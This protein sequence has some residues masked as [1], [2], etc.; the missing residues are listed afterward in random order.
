MLVHYRWLWAILASAIT[1]SC[2]APVPPVPTVSEWT[3]SVR[4]TAFLDTLER[5]TFDFFWERTNPQNG[6]TPD[7]WPTRS[8]SSIAA[9]GF[10]LTSYPIGVERGY[11]TRP[12]AR[13]RVLTTLKFFWQAPQ[14]EAVTG[15]TGNRG[16]FYHFLDLKTGQRFERVELSTIDTTLLLGGI[17]FCQVYF[18]GQDPG[19]LAIRAYADSIY[20]RVDWRW[21]QQRRPLVSMGWD[22]TEGW[23]PYDWR[24]YNEAMLLYILALGSP[25]FPLDPAAWTAYTSSFRWGRFYGQEH[26]GFAPLFGH[27]YSHSFI[28]FRG[29]QDS[30]MRRRGIDYFENSRRATYGQRVYAVVNPG[31]WAGYGAQEWGLT[32]SDGPADTTLE[33]GGR[34]RKFMEY[35]ARGASFIE[36]RDDG[37]VAPT[38]A[39]G[40]LAFAPEIAL[41]A[42][43]SMREKHGDDVFGQY[44]FLDAFNETFP[45]NRAPGMGR[46]IPGRGW[47]DTDYLG[48]DQGPILIMAENYRT[49]LVW[50]Y[51][52][53]HPAIIRGLRRAGFTGGWLDQVPV[54]SR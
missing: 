13:D 24:G 40:S 28:D 34:T 18:D 38:A 25:T 26:V 37:T 11:I 22:Q 51:M 23:N 52:R 20:R 12:E 49:G 6:L 14:G 10:A 29:I 39:G 8:F 19:E 30:Y 31:K 4:Q 48:I 53:K 16:F 1:A 3:P 44:G 54:S 32:A 27:Q 17:L 5:R 43:L 41:P 35:A 46:T 15:M 21:A 50:R 45:G 2:S 7:R 47:Y 9:V 33:L 42:L 36:V